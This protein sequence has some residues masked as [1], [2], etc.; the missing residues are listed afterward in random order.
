[1][2]HEPLLPLTSS[3]MEILEE[4]VSQYE[5]A[6]D[7][8]V[9]HYLTGPKRGL[10]PDT[11]ISA[12]LGVV[13]D[14]L[15]GHERYEGWLCIPYLGLSDEVLKI[16]FR[17]WQDHDH[18]EHRHGKYE[19]LPHAT[20]RLFNVPAVVEADEFICVTEGEF[21]ALVLKQ[22]GLPAVALP[23]ATSWRPHYRRILSG[24]DRIFLFGDPD[25]AGRE[26]NRTISKALRQ[27]VAVKLSSG[28]VTESVICNGPGEIYEALGLED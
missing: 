7:E 27:S 24:F 2:A 3:E 17:C 19:D 1:M 23:G 20:P 11:A 14:P 22:I 12:R 18:K 9:A 13:D 26:F 10:E 16:R 28:D 8:E 5:R 25:D 6:I 4:A 21:D 15:P